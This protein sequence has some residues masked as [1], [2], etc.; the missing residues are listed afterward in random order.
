MAINKLYDLPVLVRTG[1]LWLVFMAILWTIFAIGLAA[2]PEAWN[3]IV[4][5][6]SEK[7]WNVFGYIIISNFLIL[8]LIALGNL[9]VRFGNIT[10]GLVILG[11]QA[12]IIGWTAGTNGFTEPFQSVA[13]ANTAF[14]H[15]GLWE[16]TAYVLLCAVTLPKSLLTSRTFPAK[17]WVKSMP[18]KDLR[19][20]KPEIIIAGL[21]LIVLC[22]AAA[23]EAFPP[24]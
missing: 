15:I 10:P 18:L 2:H 19:F 17:I 7:G 3:N 14:L 20:T 8:A 23:A 16:T 5:A 4:P 12:I 21:S 11:I 9:F 6:V 13:A 1:L 22:F 24:G